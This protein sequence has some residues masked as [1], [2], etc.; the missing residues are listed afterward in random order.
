M[1]ATGTAEETHGSK[2]RRGEELALRQYNL[3]KQTNVLR[4]GEVNKTNAVGRSEVKARDPFNTRL[5]Q[6]PPRNLSRTID[7]LDSLDC[8]NG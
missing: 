3:D 8:F 2:G 1:R 5:A 6:A 7:R 4:E